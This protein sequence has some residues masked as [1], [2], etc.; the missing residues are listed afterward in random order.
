MDILR[1]EQVAELLDCTPATAEE[2]ARNGQLPAT[3]IG[4]SWLFPREALLK[5]LNE[6]ASANRR[7]VP[8]NLG[9]IAKPAP[10]RREPPAL[11]SF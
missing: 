4:R 3:K 6:M 5:R 8:P 1:K 9:V 11:P 10:G 2:M 7:K